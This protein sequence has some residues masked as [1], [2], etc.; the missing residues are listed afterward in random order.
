M[1]LAIII[2][3]YKAE[4]HLSKTLASVAMQSIAHLIKVYLIVDGEE[5]GKYNNIE[6]IFKNLLN[7]QFVYNKE[8][9]GPGHA[10]QTGLDLMTEPYLMF[11]D[12]DDALIS[13]HTCKHFL[14]N[15]ESPEGKQS[16]ILMGKIQQENDDG[17]FTYIQHNLVWLMGKIYRKSFIDKYNI[18]FTDTYSAEDIGFLQQCKIY[19]NKNERIGLLNQIVYDW[20]HN[21]NSIT[22]EDN[23][24]FQLEKAPVGIVENV[25]HVIRKLYKEKRLNNNESAHAYV[26]LVLSS[27]YMRYNTALGLGEHKYLKHILE[28]TKKAYTLLQLLNLSLFDKSLTRALKESLNNDNYIQEQGGRIHLTY[29]DFINLLT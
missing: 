13:T 28:Q 29:E 1:K 12:A 21:E 8:N 25:G 16:I 17:S 7:I 26:A 6:N 24:R 15:M 14:T 11:V 23:L 18:R 9:K 22:R 5:E 19:S 2:P 27:L 20:K 4:E 10:R 3:V